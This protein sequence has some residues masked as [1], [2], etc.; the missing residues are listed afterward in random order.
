MPLWRE[1]TGFF[2]FLLFCFFPALNSIHWV[3][4]PQKLALS[5][6]IVF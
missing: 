2:A 1:S 6:G 4:G 5:Y 3:F